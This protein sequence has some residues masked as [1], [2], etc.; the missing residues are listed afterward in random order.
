[1]RFGF[2]FGP[3]ERAGKKEGEDERELQRL[4]YFMLGYLEEDGIRM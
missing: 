1:V 4:I 3:L 2:G